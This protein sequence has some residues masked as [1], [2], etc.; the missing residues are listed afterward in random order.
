[1]IYFSQVNLGRYNMAL[2]KYV[3]RQ[4]SALSIIS[5]AVGE[6]GDW[7]FSFDATDTSKEYLVEETKQ[8]DCAVFHQAMCLLYGDNYRK[9][10]ICDKL[11]DVLIYIDFSGTFNRMRAS[12]I[13]YLVGKAEAM[14]AKDGIELDFGRGPERFVAFERSANM[15]RN[16]ML[17][18]IRADL[19]EPLRE[20]IMLGM[21]VGDCQLAKLYA[22]NGLMYTNGRRYEDPLFLSEKKIIVIDNP[23]SIAKDAHIIT[24]E[25]DG[26]DEPMREYTRVEKTADVEVLEFDG[27]GIISKELAHSLDPSGNHHSFQIRMPYIKGVVH[28]VD[29]KALFSELGVSKIVDIWGAEHPVSEV[30]MILTKSMF[31]G[32]GWMTEN[33]LSWAEYLER[34][35]RYGHALYISGSDKVRRQEITELNYQF[36]NTLALTEDEFRPRDLPLGWDGSPESDPRNWLTKTTETAYYDLYSDTGKRIEHFLNDLT[37]DELELTDRRRQRAEL[38]KKNPLFIEESVFAKEL[39]DKAESIRMDYSVGQILVSGDNRY[40]SDDLIRLLA[41]IVK[42]S[43]GEG[44]AY[45]V[46]TAE[47]LHGNEIYAP[48]PAYKE[49]QYYTLLRSPHIARNEEAF[50]Y[51]ISKIGT[52]R[53]KYLSHLFYVL[54]VDSRSL[55]PE[56]L[57]GADYDGDMIKTIADPLVNE[58]VKR[59]YENGNELPVLKIPAAEPLIA[60]ANDWVA[61]AKTVESTFSSRVGQIS[62]AALKCGIVAYD[63]NGED[64]K[65]ET[66]RRDVEALAI[67]TGLEID[68]AKSG[69]KPDLTEYLVKRIL[70]K[71]LFLKYKEIVGDRTERK[72]YEPTPQR[73]IKQFIESVPWELESSNLERLPYYAYT[74]EKETEQHEPKPAEDAQLFTFASDPGWKDKLDPFAMERVRS[75][76]SAYHAA[77][78]RI[79]YIRHLPT[80]LKRKTDVER[81]LFA[82]GQLDEVSADD[83]Y[84]LFDN[85]SPYNIRK[86][87]TALIEQEW[88]LTPK[89]ERETAW[90]SIAPPGVGSGYIDI[91]CDFRKNGYRLLGNILCDLDEL[92]T[93]REIKKNAIKK[94]DHPYLQAILKTALY[95]D[96]YREAITRACIA[97]LSPPDRN[98]TRI[99]P[100]EAVKCAV[101]LGERR[102]V[103]E[104]LPSA[105]LALTVGPAEEKTK[106]RRLFGR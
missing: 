15:S 47:E 7:S 68:S 34:C 38:L 28:E 97:L 27:E 61:R 55:I 70:K 17:S 82:R 60:D 74:L 72:W 3:I 81:I 42:T 103:L 16:N 21:T 85:A 104:V 10:Q 4:I 91:F 12:R 78:A 14:L 94:D 65:R 18:F 39:S 64:E 66:S 63:E 22:Y 41:Y 83:L 19:Y 98:E 77:D 102:F 32:F 13:L 8:E 75:I 9:E 73:R 48:S 69:V 23:K 84:A 101:A 24:V 40:L 90:Y 11:K 76:I 96:D 93:N 56:R 79:R 26:S 53:K 106:K 59:G 92:Y 86:A 88:H 58:C 67:L 51:P 52:I 62:N 89:D 44:R 71:S 54:M 37:D 36:L 49:Q 25:D 43:V 95:A 29:H 1:M 87:R 6:Y 45:D 5:T 105:A 57:G 99:D 35:R 30:E 2:R 46:L 31:K 33:G 100:A 80:N 20:R 50:V